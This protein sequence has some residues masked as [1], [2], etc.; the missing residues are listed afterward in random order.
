VRRLLRDLRFLITNLLLDEWNRRGTVSLSRFYFRRTFRFC[1]RTTCWSRRW[2]RRRCCSSSACARRLAACD[3]RIRQLLSAALLVD[4]THLV[5]RCGGTISI[6]CGRG[7]AARRAVRRVRR[8]G[9]R[10][11]FTLR[12][13]SP[14]GSSRRHPTAASGTVSKRSRCSRDGVSAWGLANCSW[15]RYGTGASSNPL[16]SCSTPGRLA[17]SALHEHP[18]PTSS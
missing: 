8:C 2:R 3:P 16:P 6:C 4:W 18:G 5:A 10:P 11:H 17:A 12:P 13:G 14:C 9:G 1:R 15:R 7:A